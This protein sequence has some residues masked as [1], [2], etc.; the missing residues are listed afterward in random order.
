MCILHWGKEVTSH[1]ASCLTSRV[2]HKVGKFICQGLEKIMDEDTVIG[3]D[4]NDNE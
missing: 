2:H 1:M 3:T 4:D